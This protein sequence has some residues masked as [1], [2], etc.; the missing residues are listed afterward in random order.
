VANNSKDLRIVF[1]GTPEFSAQQL[2]ALINADLQVVAAYTQP[3]RPGK[4]GKKLLPSPVKLLACK[5][6]IPVYQPASLRP[7]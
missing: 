6:N 4:R 7:K 1:A 2:S 3:D 5:H